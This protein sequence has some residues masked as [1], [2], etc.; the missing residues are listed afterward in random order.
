M[1]KF[2]NT[3]IIDDAT[4]TGVG[5]SIRRAARSLSAFIAPSGVGPTVPYRDG[6]R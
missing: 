1:T 3:Q 4:R 2:L 6:S 5:T